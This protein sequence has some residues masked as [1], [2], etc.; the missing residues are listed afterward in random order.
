[1][2]AKN[3]RMPTPSDVAYIDRGIHD[4]IMDVLREKRVNYTS[5]HHDLIYNQIVSELKVRICASIQPK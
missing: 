2:T 3:L 4:Y 5:P 1:M